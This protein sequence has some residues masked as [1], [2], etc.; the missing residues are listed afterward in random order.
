[1][2]ENAFPSTGFAVAWIGCSLQ[3][4]IISTVIY[5]EK[6]Y[7]NYGNHYKQIKSTDPRFRVHMCDVFTTNFLNILL[8]SMK[9]AIPNAT[10]RQY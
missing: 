6:Y 9:N 3:N 8:I 10:V 2:D 7:G 4:K 5:P 1:M